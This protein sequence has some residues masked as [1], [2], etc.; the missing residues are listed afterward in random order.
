MIE[1]IHQLCF[2][3]GIHLAVTD[4]L[5]Q[6]HN[7]DELKES[8]FKRI[9]ERRTVSSDVLHYLSDPW[10]PNDANDYEIFNKSTK[11]TITKTLVELL[12]RLNLNKDVEETTELSEEVLLSTSSS[13]NVLTLKDKLELAIK[14]KVVNNL[15]SHQ[16]NDQKDDPHFKI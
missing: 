13:S 15:T 11:L 10:K 9:K 2:A 7:F 14:E 6:K 4:I 12:L 1:P 8:L 5:Y 3:N 16:S